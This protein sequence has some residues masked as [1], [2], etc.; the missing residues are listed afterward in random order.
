MA[1]LNNSTESHAG[2]GVRCE[3]NQGTTLYTNGQSW[4]KVP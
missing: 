1:G 2:Q 4:N 3:L